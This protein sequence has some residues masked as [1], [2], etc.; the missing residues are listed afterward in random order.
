VALTASRASI[1]LVGAGFVLLLALSGA[2][3]ATARKAGVALLGLA[4]LA[5]AAPLALSALEQRFSTAP[6]QTDYDERAAFEKAAWLMIADHPMGVGANQYVIVANV[7]G[8]SD[9]AG[10]IPYADS[11]RA[12]VHNL[13]LLIAAETGWLGLLLVVIVFVGLI[14]IAL[15]SA[16]KFRRDDRGDILLGLAV[17]ILMVALHSFF[18]WVLITFYAQYMFAITA[19]LIV[20]IARQMG[21]FSPASST[22]VF[23]GKAPK[24]EPIVAEH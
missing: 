10:V 6:L 9:R 23:P 20:G 16:F 18:E 12:H 1:G 11:R 2:R 15:R 24:K 5:V 13:Y 7:A 22:Q 8:Y 3:R 21:Y 4:L 14:T 17:A 19:G